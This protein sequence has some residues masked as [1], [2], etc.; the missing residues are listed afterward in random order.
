MNDET[1][2]RNPKS[3]PTPE[4]G[5]PSG[6]ATPSNSNPGAGGTNGGGQPNPSSDGFNSKLI[7]ASAKVSFFTRSG[8]D[9]TPA[10]MA[11]PGICV[12]RYLPTFGKAKTMDDAVNVAMG[13]IYREV[14]HANSGARNYAPSDLF[15]ADVCV[16]SLIAWYQELA[17]LSGLLTQVSAW[18]AYLGRRLVES[19]GYDYDDLIEDEGINSFMSHLIS[20]ATKI[21]QFTL[22]PGIAAHRDHLELVSRMYQDGESVKSQIYAFQQEGFYSYEQVDQAKGVSIVRPY[23][24][25][26]LK[27]SDIKRISSQLF[28]ALA[29]SEDI[30]LMMGDIQ[31][32]Y[33]EA[34]KI[35]LPVFADPAVIEFQKRD[36][37]LAAIMN[38]TI[39]PV[40]SFRYADVQG[41]I[42][43]EE[44]FDTGIDAIP[45]NESGLSSLL[46]ALCNANA[47]TVGIWLN[48]VV[49]EGIKSDNILNTVLWEPTPADVARM[50]RF[51]VARRYGAS[52]VSSQA[53]LT[54]DAFGTVVITSMRIDVAGT[55]D[56]SRELP[57]SLATVLGIVPDLNPS[58][59][60]WTAG[61]LTRVEIHD[62][63]QFYWGQGYVIGGNTYPHYI[64]AFMALLTTILGNFDW[65][66][67]ISIWLYNQPQGQYTPE[68]P[69]NVGYLPL[70][71]FENYAVP[72]AEQLENIHNARIFNSFGLD[73]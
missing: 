1:K 16:E 12:F 54:L 71:D 25:G 2:K 42:V 11:V 14:R 55:Y 34:A 30:Y 4:D 73:E 60:P 6:G 9:L 15:L 72:S 52:R 64:G 21:K 7:S 37:I 3:S 13:K 62:T 70:R 17:R 48:T 18:N 45:R 61:G 32:C 28:N 39:V 46:N 41:T 50:T 40:N 22:I 10:G 51:T 24:E 49:N 59:S 68:L 33:G 31:K 20:L 47:E 67:P 29:N 26:L 58:D 5:V 65:H 63:D 66:P 19:L 36:D 69:P 43:Q 27:L 8:T 38:A 35:N 57:T 53:K 44:Q 56:I 23:D